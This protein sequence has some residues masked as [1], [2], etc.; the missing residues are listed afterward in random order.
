MAEP[1]AL[2]SPVMI[3]GVSGFLG[4]HLAAYLAGRGVEIVGTT[5]F[6][7]RDELPEGVSRLNTW[8]GREE[9]ELAPLLKGIPAVVNFAGAPLKTRPWT[10]AFRRRLRDSRIRSAAALM[11]ALSSRRKS[12]RV[13][14]G[15]AVGVYGNTKNRWVDE[16]SPSGR[17][18]L[19]DLVVDWETAAWEMRP[20]Q[21][22][23]ALL[24]TGVVLSEEGGF[25]KRLHSIQRLGINPL[26]GGGRQWVSWIHLEDY[27]AAVAFLLIDTEI[28][29]PVNLCAPFPQ[30]FA[31]LTA[32]T[33]RGKIKRL[34]LHIPA[35]P[36]RFALG[37]AAEP[38]LEGQ[39][40]RSKRLRDAGFRFAHPK[41][42]AGIQF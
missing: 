37:A 22:S 15:S 13:L 38:L 28:T 17:G 6:S 5:R 2:P 36:V 8:N 19:A 14:Q 12:V 32:M 18:F 41:L 34:P 35:R 25:L 29:G 11:S 27:L 7:D 21:V 31:A 30:R 26:P 3:I 24:R 40:A 23:L 4:R 9:S 42:T 1:T 16:D 39:R 20:R 33:S 10:P